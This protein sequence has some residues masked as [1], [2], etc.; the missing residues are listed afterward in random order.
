MAWAEVAWAEV[1]WALPAWDLV[2]WV[3]A[4]WAEVAWAGVTVQ[5]ETERLLDRMLRMLV[6]D[7]QNSSFFLAIQTWA[8]VELVTTM[9][10]RNA[11]LTSVRGELSEQSPPTQSPDVQSRSLLQTAQ[12]PSVVS[13]G[14]RRRR[15]CPQV[16][17]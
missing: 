11:T 17:A 5:T 3:L 8:L 10:H 7:K 1:A 2:G 12:K 14:P 9:I 15:C 13:R 6:A 16:A 4:A